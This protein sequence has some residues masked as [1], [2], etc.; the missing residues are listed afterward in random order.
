MCRGCIVGCSSSSRHQQSMYSWSRYYAGYG[1]RW[2]DVL[3]DWRKRRVHG[4]N[5]RHVR[6]CWHWHDESHHWFT[7]GAGATYDTA[8]AGAL[9]SPFGAC[10]AYAS[11][12]DATH[13]TTGADT[14]Y[15]TTGAGTMITTG[16]DA[17]CSLLAL[18]QRTQLE[19][20][21]RMTRL[22]LVRCTR[23]RVLAPRSRP[24]LARCTLVLAQCARLNWRRV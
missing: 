18:T 23:S 24:A 1:W 9:Y 14:M 16:I 6:Y 20:V 4:R 8:G 10:T 13:D 15:S 17:V 19:L 7:G 3:H 12:A 22:T 11:G 5:W 21:P 2:C